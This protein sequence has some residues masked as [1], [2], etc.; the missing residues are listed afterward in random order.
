[1]GCA[2]G[3]GDA[4]GPPKL[5]ARFVRDVSVF[6]GTQMAPGT[7]FTKIWRLK[8]VGE[9]AWPAGTK[10]L[11]VGG[12]QMTTEMSVPL[13]RDAPVMPGEEVDVAVEMCAPTELGRYLGYWRLTGPHGRRKFGQRVWCHIQVVDPE[14]SLDGH[15]FHNLHATLAEI[16]SKKQSLAATE[17]DAEDAE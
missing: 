17:K 14:Q 4:G 12:D 2:A 7:P 15:H 8:N 5:A 6:D 1:M 16:E 9:V 11:F 13:S 3:M 10:M